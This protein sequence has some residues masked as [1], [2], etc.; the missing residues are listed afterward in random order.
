MLS[1]LPWASLNAVAQCHRGGYQLFILG[2]SIPLRD[3]VE[4]I[5]TFRR[6]CPAPVVSLRR[7]GEPSVDAADYHVFPDDPEELLNK[8]AEIF[9]QPQ[10]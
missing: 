5:N 2:H 1:L 8:V 3:K 4:L 10:N 7:G 6:N 9:E